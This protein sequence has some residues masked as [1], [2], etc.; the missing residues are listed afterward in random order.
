MNQ[1]YRNL[2]MWAFFGLLFLLAMLLQTTVFG[3]VRILGVKLD[4]M[5]VVMVCV[6]LH[7]GHEAGGLFGLIAGFVWFAAGADDGIP[8]MVTFT[9][10]GI[11][12]GWLCD[13]LFSRRIWS[14]LLLSLGGLLCHELAVFVL[15]FYLGGAE[16]RLLVWALLTTALSLPA[17]PVIYLLAK[18]IRKAGAAQ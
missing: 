11:L 2:M 18:A 4:L 9:V 8:A 10:L 13:N 12:S 15:K 6:G 7:V 5:P 3:R 17:C 1:K 16:G 14:A